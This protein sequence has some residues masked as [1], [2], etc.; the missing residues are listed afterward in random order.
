VD[1]LV[2]LSKNPIVLGVAA[3][4]GAGALY[5]EITTA[6]ALGRMKLGPSDRPP[7]PMLIRM[8]AASV[9]V[10]ACAIVVAFAFT[11]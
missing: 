3:V 9:V 6:L 11:F 8:V 2:E 7:R 1:A 5:V 4:L 10:S